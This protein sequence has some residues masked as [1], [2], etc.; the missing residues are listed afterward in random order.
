MAARELQGGSVEPLLVVPKDLIVSRA[1]IELVA[2]SDRHL[3]EV[4]EAVGDFGRV[5][6]D[7]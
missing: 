2:R 5:R 6:W 7:P 3:R 4:L 1:N